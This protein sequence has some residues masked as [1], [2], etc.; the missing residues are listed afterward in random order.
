MRAPGT[1]PVSIPWLDVQHQ[2]PCC[3][4]EWTRPTRNSTRPHLSLGLI[5]FRLRWIQ[6]CDIE[7]MAGNKVRRLLGAIQD[8]AYAHIDGR[9]LACL[10]RASQSLACEAFRGRVE[11]HPISTLSALWLLLIFLVNKSVVGQQ[12]GT[13]HVSGP[14]RA[15]WKR[16][17]LSL[18]EQ[19]GSRRRL[20]RRQVEGVRRGKKNPRQDQKKSSGQ[21]APYYS[22][23][24]QWLAEPSR[25]QRSLETTPS[26][27]PAPRASHDGGKGGS[28]LFGTQSSHPVSIPEPRTLGS[29]Q[30]RLASSPPIHIGPLE[31]SLS[32]TSKNAAE[33]LPA[34]FK[35]VQL[36]LDLKRVPPRTGSGDSE[37]FPMSPSRGSAGTS[38]HTFERTSS[39]ISE[40]FKKHGEK[41]DTS[42]SPGFFKPKPRSSG[43]KQSLLG[44]QTPGS[45]QQ[46]LLEGQSS[47]SLRDLDTSHGLSRIRSSRQNILMQLGSGDSIRE[48]S[49]EKEQSGRRPKK[50]VHKVKQAPT[51]KKETRNPESPKQMQPQFFPKLPQSK[52]K[53]GEIASPRAEPSHSHKIL[54]DWTK[55][56]GTKKPES[57]RMPESPK[58]LQPE[59]FPQLPEPKKGSSQPAKPKPSPPPVDQDLQGW[60]GGVDVK[61]TGSSKKERSK[62]G[63]QKKPP[64]DYSD[65]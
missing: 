33:H 23:D 41:I 64:P 11:M 27:V 26:P 13:S 5:G 46:H 40:L 55:S 47:G 39:S 50:L 60:T 57:P 31:K 25:P 8:L 29:E 63:K 24:Q 58:N 43:S 28:S 32:D 59:S 19:R 42:P 35:P 21:A 62:K 14:Q 30:E 51:E 56:L 9:L 6:P 44:E 10:Q 15:T 45:S 2:Y 4:T 54:Q 18:P 34:K 1:R 36:G 16:S 22:S 17:A 20:R 7:P 52:E 37:V 38:G 49:P 53:E 48:V 61:K 65:F 3:W 12:S